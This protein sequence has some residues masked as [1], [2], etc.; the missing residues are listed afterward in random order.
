MSSQTFYGHAQNLLNAL[1]LER[2]TT[3]V[4]IS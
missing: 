2:R 4:F 1:T 3:K